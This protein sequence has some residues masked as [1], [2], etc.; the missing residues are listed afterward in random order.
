MKTFPGSL[1]Q[2]ITRYFSPFGPLAPVVFLACAA[3]LLFFFNRVALSLSYFN[4]LQGVAGAWKLFFIG[5]RMDAIILCYL[6]LIPA[7][8]L[9]LLPELGG[10]YW[11]P[12]FSGLFALLGGFF[13]FMEI[14]THPFLAEYS[15]RPNRL[16]VEY[17]SNP[18]EVLGTV[19]GSHGGLLITALLIVCVIMVLGARV[20]HGLLFHHRPW[21]YPRRLI[22]L[23]LVIVT[24]LLGAR[25]SIGQGISSPG[26]AVFS[27]HHIVNEIANNS[28][29]NMLFDAYTFY[30]DEFDIPAA[31]GQMEEKEIIE[32]V[33]RQ[34]GESLQAF[35]NDEIPLMRKAPAR[36]PRQRPLNLVMILAEGMD[37]EVIASLGG[38]PLSPNFD[39]LSREGLLFTNLQATGSR[40]NRGL[41]AVIS[42]WAPLPSM[43]TVKLGLA[44]NNFFTL[45]SLLKQHGYQSEFIHGGDSKFDNMRGFLLGNGFSQVIDEGDFDGD[46]WRGT[47]GV[48]DE[49]VLLRA[50]REFAA[51]GDQPFFSL[52]LTL[53]YHKPYDIP[54]G[55]SG[56]ADEKPGDKESAAYYADYALGRFFEQARREEYFDHTLFVIVAD[57]H[58]SV[59]SNGKIFPIDQYRIPALI[60]GPGIEAGRIER[61]A[62]QIDL[63]PTLLPLLG[64]EFSHPMPGRDLL[65]APATLAGRTVHIFNDTFGYR[66]ED[67]LVVMKP[68]VPAAQYRYDKGDLTATPLDEELYRDALSQ[69]LFSDLVYRQQRYA[70]AP[71]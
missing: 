14:A 17:L 1:P 20:S 11:K 26:L 18:G 49:E 28:S 62:S 21:S 43:S 46:A 63:A 54:Q 71:R 41:E 58:H 50:N 12:L 39:A 4:E 40:T 45:A 30:M 35:N 29:Y 64:L 34:T 31:Y 22:M 37:T 59:H 69:L 16:F 67:Q 8:L 47:W 9:L 42:G 56:F 33:R 13:V 25:S 51:R 57:H 36:V 15:S 60:I 27:Q 70:N 24:L 53:S 65:T 38:K 23:P 48:A 10:R 7:I 61:L 32:R 55:R 5:I 66:R 2:F 68:D 6:L 3:F 19:W 44:Q 52:I